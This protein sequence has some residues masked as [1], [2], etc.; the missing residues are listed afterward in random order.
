MPNPASGNH[1]DRGMMTSDEL[2]LEYV[3]RGIEIS[4]LKEKL[5][6]MTENRDSWKREADKLTDLII[7]SKPENYYD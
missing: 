3:T 5:K 6:L 7:E 4:N 2:Y 1:P